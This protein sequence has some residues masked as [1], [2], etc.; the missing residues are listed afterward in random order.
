M[1]NDKGILHIFEPAM[2]CSS[3]VCGPDVDP[4]LIAFAGDVDWLKRQGVEIHRY[5]LSQTPSAFIDNP[6]VYDA[7]SGSGV[8]ALPLLV[9]NGEVVARGRYPERSELAVIAGVDDAVSSVKE[10]DEGADTLI[11]LLDTIPDDQVESCCGG[12]D[13]SCC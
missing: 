8:D 4:T 13:C 6:V 10:A 12:D 7:I 3:G 2:C 9:V 1:N 5:N 11:T